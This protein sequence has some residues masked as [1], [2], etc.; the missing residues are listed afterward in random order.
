MSFAAS[1]AFLPVP[2]K[3]LQV[4]FSILSPSVGIV[5]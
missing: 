2:A 4:I 3:S 5:V 1:F